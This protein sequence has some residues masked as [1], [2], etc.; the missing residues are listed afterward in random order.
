MVHTHVLGFRAATNTSN[1][2]SPSMASSPVTG[3][4]PLAKEV[5][6]KSP[7]PGSSRAQPSRGRQNSMQTLLPDARNRASP[8][9]SSR[10]MNGNVASNEANKLATVI[11][12]TIGENKNPQRDA[13]K[14]K[15]EQLVGDA[16]DGDGETAGGLHVHS[17]STDRSMKREES[18]NGVSSRNRSDRPPSISVSARGGAKISKTV[19]PVSGSFTES[20]RSRPTRAS[21]PALK[22]SHKKG[23]GLAAQL[24]A[25]AAADED[26]S[27]IQGDEEDD[28]DGTEP[29]Y[30][31]CNQISYGEMVACDSS[32]CSREWFHLDC[33][34]LV[35]A[36]TKGKY[37]I[38]CTERF[39]ADTSYSQVVL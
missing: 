29:R 2:N 35:K 7:I 32:D 26:G 9:A 23:A 28:E 19:T 17:R 4:F 16:D 39:Q 14:S 21:E 24:A 27:S 38:S 15:G 33:A 11:G 18:Q 12:R 25:A 5:H 3:A 37:A 36:P 8:P 6:R 10:Y 13:G 20:Q 34:G 22:R 31:Y 1:I 30:C